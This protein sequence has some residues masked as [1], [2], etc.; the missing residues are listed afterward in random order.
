MVSAH[1]NA[2]ETT[3]IRQPPK[4]GDFFSP[5]Q[6]QS[7][8]MISTLI[9]NGFDGQYRQTSMTSQMITNSLA[10][11]SPLSHTSSNQFT[12]RPQT[13]MTTSQQ[14]LQQQKVNAQ[15]KNPK[16]YKTELC[17]SWMDHG[18]CNYGERC[19]YAH[20]E[21]E[22]RPIPRHPKYKTEAC[23]SYHKNGYCPYG[24][25][26]HFQHNE[27]PEVLA[28]L[29]AQN[30]QAMATVAQQQQQQ[31]AQRPRNLALT[32]SA[33]VSSVSTP[34][35]MG[36]NVGIMPIGSRPLNGPKYSN[37]PVGSDGE[38][39]APSSTDSGSESPLGSFSP[40]LDYDDSLCR[41]S[42]NSFRRSLSNSNP[43]WLAGNGTAVANSSPLV[44][45]DFWQGN[46]TPLITAFSSL[47]FE[48]EKR[49]SIWDSPSTPPM[50]TNSPTRLPVF[51]RLI[52]LKTLPFHFKSP[53]KNYY[54]S[55]FQK[56]LLCLK[57][58]T[59]VNWI[60]NFACIFFIPECFFPCLSGQKK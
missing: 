43:R 31:L 42:P 60:S 26:C 57:T 17:R 1:P 48:E 23:Q 25:R 29:I 3:A 10:R 11:R 28:Q 4:L 35:Q 9:E 33:P 34:N 39:S 59:F 55:A 14:D 16:L 51:E 24:F 15:P 22:K 12:A 13:L 7:N 8:Q 44:G 2:V 54:E 53:T 38:S 40:G 19:Q 32:M 52:S 36:G 5:Y 49:P 37:R 50:K 47:N 6:Q 18:R 20:G 21:S 58:L 46:D 41:L 27:P 30:A 56:K 45:I